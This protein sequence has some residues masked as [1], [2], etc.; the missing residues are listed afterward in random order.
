KSDIKREAALELDRNVAV[1]EK[2]PD[3]NVNVEAHSESQGNANYSLGL[4]D[5]RA[6][7]TV[8][9]IVSQGID[10][11]RISGEGFGASRPVVDCK[12][13]CSEEDHATNRRS[14]FIIVKK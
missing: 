14:D 11:S 12:S 1:M 13:N 7:S 5:R 6:Q 2:Y 10:A 9:Y 8:A 4:S 3:M